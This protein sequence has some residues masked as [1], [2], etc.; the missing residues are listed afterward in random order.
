M[1]EFSFYIPRYAELPKVSLYKDQVISYLDDILK[2]NCIE[3]NGKILTPTMINNYV[4]LKVISPPKDIR[5]TDEHLAY[6][7]IVC[8]LK[9]V[10]SIHEISD[11]IKLQ[12]RSVPIEKAYDYFCVELEEAVREV[13]IT[14]NFTYESKVK[15]ETE[16]GEILRSTV[17]AF[18]NRLYVKYQLKQMNN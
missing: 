6:L 1:K 16:E 4:K 12:V 17:M 9:H 11:M 8:V 15:F 14:R 2:K 5:Y 7:I 18:A 13:F 10:F 3:E